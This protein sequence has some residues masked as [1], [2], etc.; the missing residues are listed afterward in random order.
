MNFNILRLLTFHNKILLNPWGLALYF[1]SCTYVLSSKKW[2]RMSLITNL[3][4]KLVTSR[5]GSMKQFPLFFI[6]FVMKFLQPAY[7][8]CLSSPVAFLS[9]LIMHHHF[10]ISM[11]SH[12]MEF[13]I[14][15]DKQVR[16]NFRSISFLN[17]IGKKLLYMF[18][19][20]SIYITFLKTRK[21]NYETLFL[22]IWDEDVIVLNTNEIFLMIQIKKNTISVLMESLHFSFLEMKRKDWMT[23]MRGFVKYELNFSQFSHNFYIFV[24]EIFSR[25]FSSTK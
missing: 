13:S 25:L 10:F 2:S 23:W 8:H 5:L 6:V 3:N 21:T 12:D 4:S 11:S 14:K 19:C 1:V 16:A 9:C 22:S 17:E 24:S 7:D 18:W 20:N 15:M